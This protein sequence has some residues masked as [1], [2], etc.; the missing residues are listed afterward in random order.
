MEQIS[1]MPKNI[2]DRVR[3]AQGR[4]VKVILNPEYKFMGQQ[5]N[6]VVVT[7]SPIEEGYGGYLEQLRWAVGKVWDSDEEGFEIRY[8]FADGPINIPYEAVDRFRVLR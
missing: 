7:K 6:T 4:F 2:N 8:T 3:N 1:I 5:D